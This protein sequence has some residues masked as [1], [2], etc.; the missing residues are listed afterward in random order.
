[1]DD[2]PLD[3]LLGRMPSVQNT[4]QLDVLVFPHSLPYG[5]IQHE[6]MANTSKK[7]QDR[8]DQVV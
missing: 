3:E 6:I 7:A 1:M 4:S 5:S 8:I 2:A